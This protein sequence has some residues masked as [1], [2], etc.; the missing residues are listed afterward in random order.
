MAYSWHHHDVRYAS[1][2]RHTIAL[3]PF[4][5]ITV[6][7]F[8]VQLSAPATLSFAS[9]LGWGSDNFYNNPLFF[10]RRFILAKFEFFFVR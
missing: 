8:S 4:R 7:A 1:R 3:Y 6:S 2:K 10:Y 5:F 9:P